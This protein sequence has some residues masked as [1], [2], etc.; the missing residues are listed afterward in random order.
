M[1][2]WRGIVHKTRDHQPCHGRMLPTPTLESLEPR[3][4]LSA[5]GL[6]AIEVQALGMG[7]DE[8]GVIAA[9]AIVYVDDN[10]VNDP[11]V[12]N[13]AL[14]DLLEDGSQEHPFDSVQEAI[15]AV[16]PGGQVCVADGI[17]GEALTIDKNLTLYGGYNGSDWDLPQDPSL[18]VTIVDAV[19]LNQSVVR[20]LNADVTVD[21]FTITGG[22]A[23]AGGGVYCDGGNHTI[24]ACRIVDN[25]TWNGGP[26]AQGGDGG[27]TSDSF[28]GIGGRGG[29]IYCESSALTAQLSSF[30]HCTTGDGG[31]Y[32]LYD[33]G[34]S[35][36]GG[37]YALSSTVAL[38]DCDFTF[39]VTGRAGNYRYARPSG[40]GGAACFL[41]S[42]V[43]VTGCLIQR[44]K[45]GDGIP[46]ARGNGR[47]GQGGGLFFDGAPVRGVQLHHRGERDRQSRGDRR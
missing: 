27:D 12:Q 46:A 9:S 44:N 11:G 32:G 37:L 16:D 35:D 38:A 29:A 20:I 19:G 41:D 15:E 43:S 24:R 21:G 25:T 22:H 39:N 4:L 36:G 26:A 2:H 5:D 3:V 30:K 40:R 42:A 7:T 31:E 13:P 18:Y 34:T 14:S 17:Y 8:S 28:G 10:G 47:S 45:T 23:P 6:S 33:S 1:A